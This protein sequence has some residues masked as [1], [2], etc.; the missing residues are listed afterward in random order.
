MKKDKKILIPGLG[1]GKSMGLCDTCNMA[2]GELFA[3]PS[4][5]LWADRICIPK[6]CVDYRPDEEARESK[7]NFAVRMLIDM[8]GENE[9][10]ECIEDEAF[11]SYGKTIS[12]IG[13]FVAAEMREL[14]VAE[15]VRF[16]EK[17][18]FLK[19]GGEDFCGPYL[20]SNYASAL[21]A[22][23]I[24]ARCLFDHKFRSYINLRNR[25][26]VAGIS[27]ADNVQVRNEIFTAALPNDFKM[28]AYL[29]TDP[30]I[31]AKCTKEKQCSRELATKLR[32]CFDVVLDVRNYDEFHLLRGIIDEVL[33]R[34]NKCGWEFTSKEILLELQAKAKEIQK[35]EKSRFPK[36]ERW[37][38]FVMA[39][40]LPVSFAALQ[41]G[42]PIT[43]SLAGGAVMAAKT[44]DWILKFSK[45]RN[46][47]VDFFNKNKMIVQSSC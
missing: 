34:G 7:G 20:T 21:F 47:W 30:E 14:S 37:A 36:V 23:K 38:N 26:F 24:G 28:P 19:L 44:A 9:L 29:F 46:R 11:E 6:W 40:S 10:L 45:S 27:E 16:S 13:D 4:L 5:L 12:G 17:D 39:F 25:N 43:A 15:N 33:A 31:C 3:N 42:E 2:F 22:H 8:L 1:V 18:I 41:M 35:R 32:E